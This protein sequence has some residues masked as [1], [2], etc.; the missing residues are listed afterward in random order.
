MIDHNKNFVPLHTLRIWSMIHAHVMV[1]GCFACELQT[2]FDYLFLYPQFF[3][4]CCD[5]FFLS[6]LWF[7]CLREVGSFVSLIR[8]IFFFSFIWFLLSLSSSLLLMSNHVCIKLFFHSWFG[9][10]VFSK[11]VAFKALFADLFDLSVVCLVVNISGVSISQ[12]FIC[13]E[14]CSAIILPCSSLDS[15]N[16]TSTC[17]DALTIRRSSLSSSF[18]WDLWKAFCFASFSQRSL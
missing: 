17:L 14:F 5:W 11:A 13:L 10:K 16:L 12:S 1:Q 2:I 6:N 7:L 8:S 9:V 4:I 3:S 15:L 18:S